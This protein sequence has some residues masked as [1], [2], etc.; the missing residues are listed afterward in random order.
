MA[1]AG[2]FK[3]LTGLTFG[4][5]TVTGNPVRLKRRTLYECV[6]TCGTTKLVSADHL[7]RGDST[8]CGCAYR[9]RS[10]R[11]VENHGKRDTRT[12][13]SWC[14]MIGRCFNPKDRSY[15]NYGGRGITVCERWLSFSN[16]IADMGDRP[17]A[18]SLDRIDNEK[19]YVPGN[20][21]WATRTEQNRNSRQNV[22]ID[23]H[24]ISEWSE[25]LQLPRSTLASRIRRKGTIR[26]K[27]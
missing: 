3:L 10:Y 21:K 18:H 2:K 22:I 23:G 20:C 25:Q 8:S 1:A 14:S 11:T 5:W 24:C 27:L 19:G 16:F 7:A 9:G 17:I 13:K 12:Y 4:K 6:C 15:P 26:G